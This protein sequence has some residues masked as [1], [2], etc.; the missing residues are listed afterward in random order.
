MKRGGNG[1]GGARRELVESLAVQWVGFGADIGWSLG[2][3]VGG[4]VGD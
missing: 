1:V 4:E 3:G 2:V